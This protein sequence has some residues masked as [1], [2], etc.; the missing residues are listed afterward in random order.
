MNR[1]KWKICLK[2]VYF[3][4]GAKLKNFYYWQRQFGDMSSPHIRK[5][6]N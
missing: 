6:R 3:P 5:I 2:I 1:E 4:K